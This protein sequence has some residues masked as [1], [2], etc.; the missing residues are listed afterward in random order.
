VFR[1]RIKVYPYVSFV[2][3]DLEVLL[4]VGQELDA[5]PEELDLLAVF[6]LETH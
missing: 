4:A 5:L 3:V 1:G 2:K 6:D